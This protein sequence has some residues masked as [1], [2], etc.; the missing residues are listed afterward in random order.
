[1]ITIRL[2]SFDVNLNLV[3]KT[4][5]ILPWPLLALGLNLADDVG[6]DDRVTWV[7]FPF[8]MPLLGGHLIGPHK[9]PMLEIGPSHRFPLQ[10]SVHT[11][12]AQHAHGECDWAFDS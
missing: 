9:P 4:R 8:C 12:A 1:M 11:Q 6:F 2:Q 3:R 5:Q 7:Q 10:E